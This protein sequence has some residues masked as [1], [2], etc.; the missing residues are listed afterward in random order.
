MSPVTLYPNYV[1]KLAESYR[2]LRS[3]ADCAPNELQTIHRAADRCIRAHMR[4]GLQLTPDVRLPLPVVLQ[5]LEYVRDESAARLEPVPLPEDLEPQPM[6]SLT[7]SLV[8]RGLARL[9]Q[10]VAA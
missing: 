3:G 7:Q 4:A 2:L 5:L 10:L 8:A 1:R 9:R 6:S